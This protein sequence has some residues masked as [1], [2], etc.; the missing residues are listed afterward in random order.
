MH[1]L[2]PSVINIQSYGL[3]NIDLCTVTMLTTVCEEMRWFSELRPEKRRLH[4]R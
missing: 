3:I 2:V 1:V 4:F